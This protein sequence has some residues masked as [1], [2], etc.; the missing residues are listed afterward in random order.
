MKRK[1]GF[2]ICL[3][4][5]LICTIAVADIKIDEEHFPDEVFRKA[6]Q[7]QCDTNDDGI[8]SNAEA[9]GVASIGIGRYDETTELSSLQGIEYFT[10]LEE[11]RIQHTTLSSLNLNKNK[12]L[13]VLWLLYNSI[14]NLEI[15][16]CT[17]LDYLW[18]YDNFGNLTMLDVSK[19]KKL[20][21]LWCEGD[22]LTS[23]V[24]GELPALKTLLCHMNKLET[25]DVSKCSALNYMWCYQNILA[26]INLRG[27]NKLE[28]L[29]CERNAPLQH[30]NVTG[31]TALKELICSGT[32]IT[33][34]VLYRNTAL[35]RLVCEGIPISELDLSKNIELEELN[36]YQCE[37]DKLD[38][39]KNTKLKRLDC[40]AMGIRRLD[41]S[42]NPE[43][44]EL[45]CSSNRLMRL[46]VSKNKA[47]VRL[48]CSSSES[49]SELKLGNN[50]SLKYLN[51]Y[52]Y[53][54][55]SLL[56][57]DISRVPNLNKMIKSGKYKLK[58]L[59]QWGIDKDGDGKY[60]IALIAGENASV[61]TDGINII[62]AKASKVKDCVYT[63]E[64][65]KP[66]VTIKYK[67]KKLKK[68]KDYTIDW[69]DNKDIGNATVIVRGINDYTG[70][71]RIPFKILPKSV[72]LTSL[73]AGKEKLTVKWKKGTNVTGFVIQ[74]SLNKDFKDAESKTIYS[75]TAT[76]TEIKGLLAKKKYYVRVQ[77]FTEYEVGKERFSSSWSAV[78][79]VKTK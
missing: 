58:A 46:D 8:L 65:Q 9:E 54:S 56:E 51:C 2:L 57:I 12:K 26:E 74:Y 62:S 37:L 3:M 35:R 64:K 29:N 76:G 27:C 43:L 73:T 49:L 47:L 28:H 13:K 78:K 55:G 25:L 79:S 44:T 77:A 61:I 63:G 10:G 18:F 48:D 75:E 24:L 19:N 69:K 20:E 50:K 36:C 1:I 67:G 15:D 21:T 14:N 59:N 72:S 30:L 70:A 42:N 6:V 5:I 53:P 40:S 31:N 41:F 60:E 22:R 17:E 34:L 39:S 66:G 45:N 11:L 23:L 32:G 52:Q 38:L 68:G 4:M 16:K 71:L 7:Q 33:K